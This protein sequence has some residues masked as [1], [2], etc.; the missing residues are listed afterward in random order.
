MDRPLSNDEFKQIYSRV[1]RLCVDPIVR[2][3]AGIILTRR[4]Q[5][6]GWAGQWH[7]AGG[8]VFYKETVEAAVHRV[9][10]TELGIEVTISKLLGYMEF[11]SEEKERGFGY[12]I[13]LGILCDLQSGTPRADEQATEV[14]VFT[15]LPEDLI[16]EQKEFLKK[17]WPEIY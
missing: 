11:P 1:T 16:V 7:F 3:P 6:M 4:A 9:L 15:E 14:G 13:S 8:T 2:T 17:H 10:K 12:T 5:G